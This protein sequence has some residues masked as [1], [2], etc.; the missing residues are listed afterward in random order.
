[1]IRLK[2][3]LR[4]RARLAVSQVIGIICL[5]IVAMYALIVHV[6]WLEG[7]V[8]GALVVVL[9]SYWTDYFERRMIRAEK[10]DR[11]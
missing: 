1:M 9:F 4:F 8:A 5:I 6:V 11:Q 10:R 3:L 2:D 7:F